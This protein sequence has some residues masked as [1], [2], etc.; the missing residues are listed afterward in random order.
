MLRLRRIE[1]R[2]HTVRGSLHVKTPAR[3]A[4]RRGLW[5]I[6]WK[7]TDVPEPTQC[8]APTN[9]ERCDNHGLPEAPF[10]LCGTHAAE[11]LQ[12]LGEAAE[13][14]ASA[15]VAAVQAIEAEDDCQ[16]VGIPT[17][18]PGRDVVYYVR[19]GQLIKIGYSRDLRHRMRCYPPDAELLAFEP[20]GRT[21]ER[22]RLWQ[23]RNEDRMRNEWFTPSVELLRHIKNINARPLAS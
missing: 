5:T 22:R 4:V 23:F 16:P 21:V 14:H 7:G 1:P 12:Y 9:S 17:P 3:I 10:P 18:V 20:G 11:V 2:D 6:P 8:I 13:R 19:I 15:A